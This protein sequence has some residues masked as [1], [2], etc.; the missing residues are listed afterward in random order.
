[1]WHLFNQAIFVRPPVPYHWIPSSHISKHNARMNINENMLSQENTKERFI[2][3]PTNVG[4]GFLAGNY[5]QLFI[6][7]D[8]Q[9]DECLM[10]RQILRCALVVF[11]VYAL[12]S[13]PDQFFHMFDL[14]DV[15]PDHQD[16]LLLGISGFICMM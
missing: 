14:L 8:L 3:Q 12:I 9:D 6:L 5:K 4:W 10:R 2:P 1:M 13:I 7:S 11:D 15:I 16:R